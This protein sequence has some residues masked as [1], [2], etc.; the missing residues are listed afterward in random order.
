M[1]RKGIILREETKGTFVYLHPYGN[2]R[3]N[4]VSIGAV[5]CINFCGAEFAG[6]F[7]HEL[8]HD[9]LSSCK[10][11]A[12]GLHWYQS[13]PSFVEQVRIIKREYPEIIVAAGGLSAALM[14]RYLFRE[15]DIDFI[16]TGHCEQPF[17]EAIKRFSAGDRSLADIP[18]L[19]SRENPSGD[20]AETPHCFQTDNLDSSTL[21]WFPTLKERILKYHEFVRNENYMFFDND[22]PFIQTLRGCGQGCKG[23]Y[24]SYGNII[25]PDQ[26]MTRSPESILH[27]IRRVEAVEG[28]SYVNFAGDFITRI[29]YEKARAA[30]PSSSRLFCSYHFCAIPEFS[31]IRLLADTFVHTLAF[32]ILRRKDFD[33]NN[34]EFDMLWEKLNGFLTYC[35]SIPNLTVYLDV[36]SEWMKNKCTA[37]LNKYPRLV[38]KDAREWYIAK[39]GPGTYRDGNHLRRSRIIASR[40][41]GLQ[42]SFFTKKLLESKIAPYAD[43]KH[44]PS[45]SS[46]KFMPGIPSVPFRVH[47]VHPDR[48]LAAGEKGLFPPEEIS[49]NDIC[50]DMNLKYGL[51]AEYME[52]IIEIPAGS[53]V[54]YL[55][56]TYT[57]DSLNYDPFAGRIAMIPVVRLIR[58]AGGSADERLKIKLYFS[59]TVKS[60]EITSGEEIIF[61]SPMQ[62]FFRLREVVSFPMRAKTSEQP[63]RVVLIN[64]PDNIRSRDCLCA[65]GINQKWNVVAARQRIRELKMRGAAAIIMPCTA[66]DMNEEFWTLADF[67]TGTGMK[68]GLITDIH[69]LAEQDN[70]SKYLSRNPVYTCLQIPFNE[71]REFSATDRE[72]LFRDL[73][74]SLSNVIRRVPTPFVSICASELNL[75]ILKDIFISLFALRAPVNVILNIHTPNRTPG[76]DS[77]HIANPSIAGS[78]IEGIITSRDWPVDISIAPVSLSITNSPPCL[79]PSISSFMREIDPEPLFQSSHIGENYLLPLIQPRNCFMDICFD[80]RDFDCCKGMNTSQMKMFPVMAEMARAY[81]KGKPA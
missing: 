81:V 57:P 39:P 17:A 43:P 38:I 54:E 46:K 8:S 71:P 75:S 63:F 10:F 53:H 41:H 44:L 16:F 5:T 9:I 27:S 74:G 59:E 30:F 6:I 36:F 52:S 12:A 32:I 37:L 61:E 68:F 25:F 11:L 79:F 80:C 45:M 28:Y 35:G 33:K 64:E 62:G 56:V 23:C 26:E 77:Q 4:C 76:D 48:E 18:G 1:L 40:A 19:L 14:S 42:I 47:A 70:T 31:E 29:G 21:D 72:S 3:E 55:C 34:P 15:T 73:A 50:A 13:I 49:M 65:T 78:I 67:I 2:Y 66:P 60:L 22:L 58:P 69:T 51:N 20:P 7:S 24:G